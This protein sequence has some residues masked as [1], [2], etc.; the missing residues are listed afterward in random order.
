MATTVKFGELPSLKGQVLGTSDWVEV[1][2]EMIDA[3][4]R[5]TGDEQWIH[6]D[7]ERAKAESPYGTT[8]AHGYLTLSLVPLL[9]K[10]ALE[11]DGVAMGVNY[12]ANK[13]RF[14]APVP[15][16]SRV[17]GSFKLLEVDEIPGGGYQLVTEVTITVDGADKPSCVAETVSR[18]YPAPA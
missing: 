7:V 12:G 17:Q 9:H 15:S 13:V 14:P 10:Q 11:L 2:Q 6:M 3:F 5:T 16:G 8:I 1:T 18:V 4:G